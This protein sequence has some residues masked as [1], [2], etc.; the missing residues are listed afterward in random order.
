MILAIN[1]NIIDAIPETWTDEVWLAIGTAVRLENALILP[2]I[3]WDTEY[4][5]KFITGV[6]NEDMR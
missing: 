6:D 4:K 5:G 3:E 1:N 2:S